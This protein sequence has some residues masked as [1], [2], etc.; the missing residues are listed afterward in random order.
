MGNF[1]ESV[2]MQGVLPKSVDISA[3]DYSAEEVYIK[4]GEY[5]KA[6]R[7]F[8][9]IH[10]EDITL[11]VV[12]WYDPDQAEVEITFMANG[13]IIPLRKVKSDGTTAALK[14]TY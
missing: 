10:P 11:T 1:D 12:P 5:N 4:G 7:P 9:L 8:V 6:V 2:F 14:I 13:P 3:A